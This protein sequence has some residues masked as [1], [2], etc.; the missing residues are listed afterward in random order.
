MSNAATIARVEDELLIKCPKCGGHSVYP[1]VPG[2]LRAQFTDECAAQ[3]AAAREWWNSRTGAQRYADAPHGFNPAS[4]GVYCG[5]GALS[6]GERENRTKE[7]YVSGVLD[8][9]ASYCPRCEGEGRIVD[10]DRACESCLRREAVVY[11]KDATHLCH[12]CYSDVA[13]QVADTKRGN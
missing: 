1:Y 7:L 5:W 12:E 8:P 6:C 9:V 10:E 11:A 13:Y 2:H 3:D 4:F